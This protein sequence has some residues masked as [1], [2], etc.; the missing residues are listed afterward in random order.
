MSLAWGPSDEE[1][2][3]V[4]SHH[5]SA[6]LDCPICSPSAN[7]LGGKGEDES[8]NSEESKV[9]KEG[10]DD[11]FGHLF[12]HA[13]AA[14]LVDVYHTNGDIEPLLEDIMYSTSNNSSWKRSHL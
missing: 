12:N 7:Q 11:H 14:H 8:D 9:E 2:I 1:L 13:E 4:Q 10:M 5:I 3:N 6:N